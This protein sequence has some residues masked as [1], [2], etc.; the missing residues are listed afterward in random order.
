[1]LWGGSSAPALFLLDQPAAKDLYPATFSRVAHAYKRRLD[2]VMARGEARG[3]I[4]VIDW[5]DASP[6]KRILDLACGPGTLSYPLA[7]AV[8]PGG[9]VVGIDLATGM[10]ELARREAP[11]DLPVRF[12]LMDMEDLRFPD[13]SFDAAVSGHGFQFVPDLRRALA[14]TRRVLKPGARMAASVP[15]DPL[16]PSEAQAILER[17]VGGALP[18]APKARDQFATR[19]IVEDE[20]SFARI[21]KQA[22]FSAADVV[23]YEES[24][25]WASPQH[26]IEM[27]AGWWSMAIRLERLSP[28]ERASLLERANRAIEA[29]LGTGPLQIAGATNVLRAIA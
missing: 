26:F 21:A 6:G 7:K 4:A 22:G 13:H 12:E 24:T 1:M 15:V 9:D 16:Q 17:A 14:E 28:D 23:R 19:R 18:Q 27:S 8:S 10:I 5:V 2:E 29:A 20:E 3:R 25:S 11:L